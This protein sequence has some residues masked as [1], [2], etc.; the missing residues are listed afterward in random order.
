[1]E[2][3]IASLA[4]QADKEAFVLD[5]SWCENQGRSLIDNEIVM[6]FVCR[7]GG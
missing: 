4:D 2:R 5:I 7:V 6:I 3:L 1:M